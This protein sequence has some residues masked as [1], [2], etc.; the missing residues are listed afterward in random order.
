MDNKISKEWDK[1]GSCCR[2]EEEEE[3]DLSGVIFVENDK[4]K[5]KQLKDKKGENKMINW[6][7]KIIARLK[8]TRVDKLETEIE[9]LSMKL[10]IINE[11]YRD[12]IERINTIL[13]NID[14]LLKNHDLELML[15]NK[16]VSELRKDM[17]KIHM[18][19]TVTTKPPKA[20]RTITRTKPILKN[21]RGKK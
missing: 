10:S 19:P 20:K 8:S 5:L 3:K 13:K 9:I 1:V 16:E 17:T 21:I 14:N 2:V 6:I 7:K 11:N 15:L 4:I 18:K 12:Q